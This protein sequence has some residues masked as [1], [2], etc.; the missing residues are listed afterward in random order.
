VKTVLV[1]DDERNIVELVRLYL[2]KEGFNVVAASD[3]EQALVQYERTGPDL[4]V[5]DLMLPKMDGFEVCRELRRR[6]DVPI[7]MLTA[8]SEDVDAIVGLE[9]G[10]DDYVTKPFNPR[11]LV[12]RVKAILRRTDATARGG[13]PIQVGELRIDP[14]RREA[15][16]GDRQ[17]DLRAREFDLLAAL[18]RDPGVVLSRDAL[19]EDVWGTDFPGET[20]TVDV[21]VAEVRKKLGGDGP[22]VETVRGIG[23]RLV[24]PPRDAASAR[25]A[26]PAAA[27]DDTA[28]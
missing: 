12:A 24:P 23:Y 20:R 11:A 7:L 5:L 21:H 15:S 6:G 17:L 19:L 27:P 18:A 8:R 10:A 14:R 25:A 2:E 28:D 4:V 9:L 13:R 22:Q 1:V 3:G 26:A 16:V